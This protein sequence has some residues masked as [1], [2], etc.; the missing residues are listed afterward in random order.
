[1]M[2]WRLAAVAALCGILV[3]GC[4]LFGSSKTP[5]PGERVAV[6]QGESETKADPSTADIQVLLPKPYVN[7]D[8]PQSGGYAHFAMQ[9]LAI[10]DTPRVAWK[11]SIGEGSDSEQRL[12]SPPVVAAGR[13]F[14]KDAVNTVSAYDERTGKLIWKRDV[15]PRRN[16]DTDL[17][18]GGVA[19]YGGRLFVTAGFAQ[20]IA[21]DAND[22]REIWR[23]PVSGPVRGAP[24]VFADRVFAISIDNQTHALSAVDGGELWVNSGLAE[25]AGILGGNSPAVSGDLVVAPYSSG[26]LVGARLENGRAAWTES[27]AGAKR[28]DAVSNLSDIRG[29]P[30]ID[31]GRVIAIGNSGRIIA[32]DLRS[33]GRIWEK[34][35]GG[36]ETPWVAGDY[37]YVVNNAAEVVCILREDGRVRWVTQLRRFGNERSKKDPIKWAGPVAAGDRL[38]VAGSTGEVLAVSPY[39]GR[40]LGRIS[41]G[42]SVTIAPI[43]ANQTIFLITDDATLIALR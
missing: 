30:V 24:T 28:S 18:G 15:A 10:R 2:R 3:G 14:V 9:H 12:L 20:V 31:R 17:F 27:L 8:W 11:V 40:I 23:K 6:L 29:R 38:L 34:A 19:Y 33:G 42:Q 1:M 7:A 43:V 4:D 21:L 25:A 13:V 41:V 22:G 35:V 36:T 5:L 16:R 39:D 37:I 32:V 26:E